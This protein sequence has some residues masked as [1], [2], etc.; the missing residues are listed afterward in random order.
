MLGP[1]R[2]ATLFH[3]LMTKVL[4]YPTFRAQGGDWGSI[5]TSRL[6]YDHPDAVTA[7]HLNMAPLRPAE[8]PSTEAE[9]KWAMKVGGQMR[10]L[11]A[12]FQLQSTKPQSL[13]WAMAGNPVGQA[14]WITERFHDWCDL[15]SRSFEEVFSL[16]DLLTN[17]MIYV[18][19]DAFATSVRYYRAFAEED[20]AL[21]PGRKV[22][23]PT[24]VANFPG[25]ALYAAP[26]RSYSQKAY[27]IS[28]WTDM[29]RGGHF[30]AMEE[31]LMFVEEV[32][33]WGRETD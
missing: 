22:E 12:Y 29:P 11:G 9:I 32:R 21:P 17:I 30:A 31:P 7:I 33:A 19:S 5:V 26:P 10:A 3:G 20:F 13:I 25:E 15:S 28:R 14:A 23:T 24:A 18:M 8:D 6:A 2:T 1:S 16:D 27:N 4:A